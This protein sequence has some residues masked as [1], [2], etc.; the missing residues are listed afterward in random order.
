MRKILL[1]VGFLLIA[2]WAFAMVN[3][4]TANVKELTTLKGVG[5]KKA[6]AIVDYRKAHGAFKSTDDLAKVKGIGPKMVEQLRKDITT[7]K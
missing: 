5:E 2:V 4:N 7:K 3:I 1:V 6:Q